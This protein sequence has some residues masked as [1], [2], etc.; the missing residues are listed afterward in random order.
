MPRARQIGFSG[1]GR[2]H[3]TFVVP[4]IREKSGKDRR[5]GGPFRVC[6]IYTRLMTG[7]PVSDMLKVAY[8]GAR[9]CTRQEVAHVDRP[10]GRSELPGRTP[11]RGD[12]HRG[13][14]QAEARSWPRSFRKCS[15]KVPGHD[16]AFPVFL[17]AT[18]ERA[19]STWIVCARGRSPRDE[20]MMPAFGPWILRSGFTRNTGFTRWTRRPGTLGSEM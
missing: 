3:H 18:P 6:R 13:T 9:G 12:R 7:K 10:D 2:P 8:Q 20:S 5:Q 11:S 4:D 1:R 16:R 14:G 17:E 19:W 15:P